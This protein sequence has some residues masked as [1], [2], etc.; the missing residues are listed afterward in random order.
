[1][2][3][4]FYYIRVYTIFGKIYCILYNTMIKQSF[5]LDKNNAPGMNG[6]YHHTGNKSSP[7]NSLNFLGIFSG[8]I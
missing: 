5:L 6:W 7:S 4:R 2:L 3:Y 8:A 1:M